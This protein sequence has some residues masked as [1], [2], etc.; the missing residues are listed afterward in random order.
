MARLCCCP[1]TARWPRPWSGRS[2]PSRNA[3]V[4]STI[5]GSRTVG[6]AP[7]REFDVSVGAALPADVELYEV[8]AGV[9]YEPV[10]RYRYVTQGNRLIFVEPGSRRVIRV[11][12]P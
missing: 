12:T 11:I 6:V 5:Y 9:T 10:R 2:R 7:A 8:P 4:Y 3:A 1:P